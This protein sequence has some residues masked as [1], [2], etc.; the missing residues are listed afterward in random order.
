LK[1]Q[2]FTILELLVAIGILDSPVAFAI[3]Q[4][5]SYRRRIFIAAVKSDLKNASIVQEAYF[6]ETE[7]YTHPYLPS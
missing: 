3:P 2:G 7:T 1:S 5:N 6:K 4:Y